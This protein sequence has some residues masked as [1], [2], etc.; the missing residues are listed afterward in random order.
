MYS[1]MMKAVSGAMRVA[2]AAPAA[3]NSLP[4]ALHQLTDTAVFKRRLKSELFQQTF[5]NF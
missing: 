2:Y 4:P 1:T 3:W 5:Y